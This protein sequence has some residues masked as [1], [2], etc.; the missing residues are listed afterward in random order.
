MGATKRVKF[1][2][3]QHERRMT[4]AR[5]ELVINIT[6]FAL[7]MSG[8]NRPEEECADDEYSTFREKG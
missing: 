4:E 3:I 2:K 1:R 7:A 6:H 5:V 8:V